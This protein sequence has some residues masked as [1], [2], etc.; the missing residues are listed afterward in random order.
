MLFEA[1]FTCAVLCNV[2]RCAEMSSF[3]V[4]FSHESFQSKSKAQGFQHTLRHVVLP[5]H[6]DTTFI[7][8]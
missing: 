2:L 3:A 6:A 4:A 7:V 8:G 5:I 1:Q